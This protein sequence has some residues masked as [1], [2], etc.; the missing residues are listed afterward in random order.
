MM[1]SDDRHPGM[2]IFYLCFSRLLTELTSIILTEKTKY[3]GSLRKCRRKIEAGLEFKP[4]LA[5][6]VRSRL[7]SPLPTSRSWPLSRI[8]LTP[9]NRET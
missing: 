7:K 6:P 1:S 8:K 2:K 3:L 9:L 5:P 4:G